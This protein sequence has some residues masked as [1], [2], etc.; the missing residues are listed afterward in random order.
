MTWCTC[1]S[2][3][4]RASVENFTPY[5][6]SIDT[7]AS[8][9]MDDQYEEN[10]TPGAEETLLFRVSTWTESPVKMTSTGLNS[11]I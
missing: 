7:V 10:D 5:K 8:F 2:V 3:R 9:C 1:A 11:S 6:L 4:F